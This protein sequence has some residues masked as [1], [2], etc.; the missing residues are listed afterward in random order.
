MPNDMIT[1]QRLA[2]LQEMAKQKGVSASALVVAWMVNLHRC[3]GF[4]RVIPLFSSSKADHF[5]ANLQGAVLPL[6]DE[7]LQ[8]LNRA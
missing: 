3:D 6:T 8:S 7:E 1:G 2:F 5:A 4:P